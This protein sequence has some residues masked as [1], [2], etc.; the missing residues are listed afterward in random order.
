[1][2]QHLLKFELVDCQN[3]EKLQDNWLVAQ[4]LVDS[5]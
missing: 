1:M 2:I 3:L 5:N 4:D